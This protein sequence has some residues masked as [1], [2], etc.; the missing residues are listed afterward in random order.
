MLLLLLYTII[1]KTGGVVVVVYIYFLLFVFFVCFL[2]VFLNETIAMLKYTES[3]T[4]RRVSIW[5]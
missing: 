3:C 1:I 5:S 4:S 2:W